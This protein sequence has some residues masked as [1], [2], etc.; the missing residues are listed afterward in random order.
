MELMGA[1]PHLGLTRAHLALQSR[2][3]FHKLALGHFWKLRVEALTQTSSSFF[4]V[5]VL[6]K[7]QRNE[8]CDAHWKA[9]SALQP[10]LKG[11]DFP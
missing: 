11:F 6:E 1:R 5:F 10:G 2:D 9:D 3:A 7:K 8:T 4:F